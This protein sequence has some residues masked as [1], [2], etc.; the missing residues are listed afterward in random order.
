YQITDQAMLEVQ[1]GIDKTAESTEKIGESSKMI[2]QIAEQTNL[3]ALNAAIE[4]AR[5]GEAGRGFAV[6]AEEIRKLAEESNL[7]T[8]TID[9]LLE[10]LLANSN[11]TVETIRKGLEELKKLQIAI[12]KNRAA[13][14]EI[15][16][17]TH[18]NRKNSQD[19]NSS[20]LEIEIIKNDTL[21]ALGLLS[22]IGEGNSAATEE[23]AASVEEQTASMAEISNA[24]DAL[25]E[26]ASSL[27]ATV[28]KFK[29]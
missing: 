25:E 4:A 17:A 28:L 11:D 27:Q 29:E 22:N 12:E 7:S 19:L 1:K 24:I 14:L 3:L 21:Q 8:K 2:A 10:E 5:A 9:I 15:E 26:L 13:F 16:K 23:V 18:I 6:V 20:M